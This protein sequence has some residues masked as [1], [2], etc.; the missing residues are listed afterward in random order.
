MTDRRQ[1]QLLLLNTIPEVRNIPDTL[2]TEMRI[3]VTITLISVLRPNTVSHSIQV[4]IVTRDNSNNNN[5]NSISITNNN[6]D[7][8]LRTFAQDLMSGVVF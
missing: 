2:L 5:N 4:V 3:P 8:R 6:R 7:N 1:Q